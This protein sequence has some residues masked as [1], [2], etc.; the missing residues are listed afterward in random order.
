MVLQHARAGVSKFMAT[1]D[2]CRALETYLY[3]LWMN[4]VWTILG[5]CTAAAATAGAGIDALADNW[6]F[7]LPFVCRSAEPPPSP[8]GLLLESLVGVVISM[9]SPESEGADVLIM[10]VCEVLM[11]GTVRAP[12]MSSRS[13]PTGCLG[14]LSIA[15]AIGSATGGIKGQQKRSTGDL[16][17][18]TKVVRR[19]VMPA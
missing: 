14:A 17:Q 8:S 1:R 15:V 2:I 12:M 3:S 9:G 19:Q 13:L 4:A 11:M 6:S 16:R 5:W 18:E 7:E 10:G